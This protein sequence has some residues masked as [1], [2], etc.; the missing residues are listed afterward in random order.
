MLQTEG[1]RETRFSSKLLRVQKYS[2][3]QTQNTLSILRILEID[4]IHLPELYKENRVA[5]GHVV[6]VLKL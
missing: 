3:G 2:A 6:A 4:L 1:N 5:S